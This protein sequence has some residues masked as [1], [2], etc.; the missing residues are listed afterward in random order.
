MSRAP[1]LRWAVAAVVTLATAA[2]AQIVIRED[3]PSLPIRQAT[4]HAVIDDALKLLEEEYVFP[5][6]AAK[7]TK[8][9]RQ[10]QRNKEYAQVKTGQELAELLAE[11][12][13]EVSKDKHLNFVCSTAKLPKD[14]DPTPEMAE[15]TRQGILK[16]NAGFRRVERLDG[17]VGYLDLDWFAEAEDAAGPAAAAMNFLAHT[18]ALIIDLRRNGGGSPS[19][20][21][22]LCSYFF[23]ETP[24]HLNTLQ[25][26]Q[27]NGAEEYWTLKE[28]A[29][30][31]YQSKRVYVLTSADTF[32]GA[33][34]FA[35]NLQSHKRATIVGATTGGGAHATSERPVLDH[36]VMYL[37]VAR[38]INPITKTNWEGT[39][40]QPDVAVAADA[41]LRKARKLALAS[42]LIAT[43][44]E[45]TRREIRMCLERL[46]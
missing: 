31:R 19:G 17:N 21:A 26:R 30:K 15:R 8:A 45:E 32:S 18:D 38:S 7:M 27:G 20:V 41:A 43:Q 39:G 23:D 3:Q 9:V 40:V 2:H 1:L 10:R 13:Q 25:W 14:L 28:L 29:G 22:L 12:L 5:E 6:V 24:V 16:S 42:I 35:Y 46:K 33:E 44:D 37:P 36:F 34:E 11:H 4:V